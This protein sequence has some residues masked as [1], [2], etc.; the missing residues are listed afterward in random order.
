[1]KKIM[2]LLTILAAVMMTGCKK[3]I[4][5][6][7]DEG[8]SYVVVMAQL[9]PDSA[10]VVNLSHSR[11]F[12]QQGNPEYI[13][14]AD[15]RLWVNGSLYTPVSVADGDYCFSVAPA[16][17]DSVWFEADVPGFG[18]LSG[19]TRV[20]TR[21]QA[22]N[23][24]VSA[25]TG[26]EFW[27]MM[28][29]QY[30]QLDLSDPLDERDYYR[31]EIIERDQC[32]AHDTVEAVDTTFF[33]YF[34]YLGLKEV[35]DTTRQ[36]IFNAQMASAL[37]LSDQE[38]S[39]ETRSVG[40]MSTPIVD[41]TGLTTHD[42]WVRVTAYSPEMFKFRRSASM[43]SSSFSMFAEPMQVYTNIKGGGIGVFGS[44]SSRVIPCTRVTLPAKSRRR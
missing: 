22:D 9:E 16:A 27:R 29:L 7:G 15:M 13:N 30:I 36:D 8:A 42:Y 17:G 32:V 11:F 28:D 25:T 21:P 2:L 10:V 26:Y 20:V 44:K 24:I 5:F 14:D 18:L 40:F 4:E 23:V 43:A 38:F 6:R 41:T 33:S 37:I 34:L 39:G 12:L 1:M 31:F 35:G 19:A 3:E